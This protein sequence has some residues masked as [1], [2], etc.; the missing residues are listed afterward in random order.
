MDNKI[1]EWIAQVVVD[2]NRFVHVIRQTLHRGRVCLKHIKTKQTEAIERERD[3]LVDEKYKENVFPC[4]AEEAKEINRRWR[5]KELVVV[6]EAVGEVAEEEDAAEEE[7]HTLL[8]RNDER[9]W[10]STTVKYKLV[11]GEERKKERK[12][13]K[14]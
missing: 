8:R 2:E 4:C 3:R 12:K 10:L 5:Q 6:A 7:D 1:E 13:R 9:T 14:Y 11:R